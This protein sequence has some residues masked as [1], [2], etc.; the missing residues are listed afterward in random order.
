MGLCELEGIG[1]TRH[2]IIQISVYL[3]IDKS[4]FE[5]ILKYSIY[6]I[7]HFEKN[8]IHNINACI[9]KTYLYFYIFKTCILDTNIIKHLYK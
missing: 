3:H 7:N 2:R 8:H 4:M 1:D 5:Y 9:N 6:I